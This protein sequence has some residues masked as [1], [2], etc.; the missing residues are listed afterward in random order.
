MANPIKHTDIA[1]EGVLTN[2]FQKEVTETTGKI[3]LMQAAI[4]KVAVSLNKTFSGM[5]VEN[6][7]DVNELNDALKKTNELTV[8][9]EKAKQALLKT[10]AMEAAAAE[11]ASK[12]HL[13]AE[14]QY[15]KE[16]ENTSK[17]EAKAAEVKQAAIKK[18]SLE[19][20]KAHEKEAK[21][22][23]EIIKNIEALDK[24][25]K[26]LNDGA[27]KKQIADQKEATREAEKASKARAKEAKD[28]EKANSLY[29]KLSQQL[30]AQKKAGKD[31]LASG[32]E[33]SE[34]DKELIANT[35]ELDRRLKDIDAT[36]GDNQRNVGAY[37]EALQDVQAELGVFG[38]FLG[39]V[40]RTLKALEEQGE[41]SQT[42]MQKLG[43]VMKAVGIGIALSLIAGVAAAIER[44]KELNK[45]LEDGAE[46]LSGYKDI[47]LLTGKA[48][49]IAQ[50]SMSRY[51]DLLQKSR[52]V[53]REQSVDL[54]KTTLDMEDQNEIAA[55]A[56]IGFNE[57]IAAQK[58][59][60]RLSVE[61]AAIT[62]KMAQIEANNINNY[63][64]V[65]ELANGK[66]NVANDILQKQT[67]AQL[68]LNDAIDKQGDLVRQNAQKEREINQQ[69]TIQ[70][71]DLLLKKKESANA[72]K[73]MLEEDLKDQKNQL[74]ERRKINDT[75][76]N[77]NK[78]TTEE[79][80]DIFK[81]GFKIKFDSNKLLM[82][83]D[84]IALQQ[85]LLALKT[86][87]GHGLG[88]AGV[89]ELAKIIKQSQE[90]QIDNSK[91][92]A[93]LD[94]E[95]I[96]RQ[97][98]IFDIK[99]KITD[100]DNQ[101]ALL[102]EK[103]NKLREDNA[104]RGKINENILKLDID[105][106]YLLQEADIKRDAL[107]EQE[108]NAEIVANNTINDT[109]I[110]NEEIKKLQAQLQY[111]LNALSLDTLTKAHDIALEKQHQIKL[112]IAEEIK[113]VEQV[114]EGVK[115]GLQKREELQQESDQRMI[116]FHT[117]MA[118]VQAQLAAG[119]RENTLAEQEANAAK[120][121][122]KK[123]QDAKKAAKTQETI[124][125]VDT[126]AKT[127]QT[128]LSSNEPFPAAFGKAMTASGLVTAAFTQLFAGF[129]EGT[130]SLGESDG[131]NIGGNKDNILI[132]AHKTER[133]LGVDDSAMIPAGMSN[134]D[135]VDA[136]IAYA[137]G[138]YLPPA[139]FVDKKAEENYILSQKLDMV[140]NAVNNIPRQSV[141]FKGLAEWDEEIR[142]ANM[143]T[144]IHHKHERNR[145]LRING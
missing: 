101:Q 5:K 145:S 22:Q 17:A 90:N 114:T 61:A 78:K 89:S 105:K 132:R 134:K 45:T 7:D 130:E 11:K 81:K 25:L 54:Q 79:E 72:E 40:T 124:A 120:A 73:V 103:E 26:K 69:K 118:D 52:D 88:E 104:V 129:Y 95:E 108:K 139:V 106:K 143:N 20:E 68:K 14:K 127:L 99:V 16:I 56:T 83:Q 10:S 135:V 38:G 6:L 144:I 35:Q 77:V 49:G 19:A 3:I 2:H 59:A 70:E 55:D 76:F 142:Q 62:T 51:L 115:Q 131:M 48:W 126:F 110:L 98:K 58:E 44:G 91:N 136:S 80:I 1:E 65:L 109:K 60:M 46:K 138:L 36:F 100:I 113:A 141:N 85:K 74:E 57:R 34:Q 27:V 93:I 128:A 24:N 29:Y 140:V 37:K 63:V 117:R 47:L 43:N 122:E 31:L 41:H 12:A 13:A 112:Q 18:T 28:L 8:L 119:G 87:E 32:K 82:E 96:K 30:I 9:N 86:D 107:I 121:E 66:G 92:K 137:N 53:L 67:D 39:R 71:I 125:I 21:A 133:I 84:A 116:D 4:E 111:D 64:S 23:K 33:L 50:D 15:N 123:L 42:K 102:N 97:Q 94:D 75:L